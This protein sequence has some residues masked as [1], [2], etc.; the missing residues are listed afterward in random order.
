VTESDL[1][2]VLVRPMV[3]AADGR[4]APIFQTLGETLSEP[5]PGTQHGLALIRNRPR[6]HGSRSV[7]LPTLTSQP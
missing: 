5:Q 7:M 4:T 1:W 3:S 2:P 6:R